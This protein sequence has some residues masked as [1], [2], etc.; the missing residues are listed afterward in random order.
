MSDHPWH[1][2]ETWCLLIE[3]APIRS[4]YLRPAVIRNPALSQAMVHLFSGLDI[5][6]IC[7]HL[8]SN[9]SCSMTI[10]LIILSI[11]GP[12]AQW[13]KRNSLHISMDE[14]KRKFPLVEEKVGR[15]K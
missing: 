6:Q 12:T 1:L 13:D 11:A 10:K 14:I 4:P 15:G 2:F 5:Y 8:S 7:N 3:L 9:N